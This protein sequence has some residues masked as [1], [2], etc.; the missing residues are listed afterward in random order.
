MRN[1]SPM[2]RRRWTQPRCSPPTVRKSVPADTP[3]GK[4]PAASDQERRLVRGRRLRG[5]R[6]NPSTKDG[7]G[8]GLV[9]EVPHARSPSRSSTRRRIH[10]SLPRS[11]RDFDQ[12]RPLIHCLGDGQSDKEEAAHRNESRP[13]RRLQGPPRR[14]ASTGQAPTRNRCSSEDHLII[15]DRRCVRST[16][17]GRSVAR[18]PS[19]F[20]P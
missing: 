7:T 9:P 17:R 11:V 16:R 6:P 8:P 14:P 5:I 18:V 1:G 15:G 20:H 3:A 2:A 19:G 4:N 13:S 10:R 12:A